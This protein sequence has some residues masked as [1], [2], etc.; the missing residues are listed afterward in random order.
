[1]K[2]EWMGSDNSGGGGD[3]DGDGDVVFLRESK[4]ESYEPIFRD[5]SSSSSSSSAADDQRG[6]GDDHKYLELHELEDKCLFRFLN[7]VVRQMGDSITIHHVFSYPRFRLYVRNRS[8]KRTRGLEHELHTFVDR[9]NYAMM[10]VLAHIRHSC[11]SP[12]LRNVTLMTLLHNQKAS[13]CF[14]NLV[15]ILWRDTL[16]D[17]CSLYTNAFVMN[18]ADAVTQTENWAF[19][20]G[21]KRMPEMD[22]QFQ[23][24][25]RYP[26]PGGEVMSGP[27]TDAD[28]FI[29]P[30]RPFVFFVRMV[31]QCAHLHDVAHLKKV[32]DN[33]QVPDSTLDGLRDARTQDMLGVVFEGVCEMAYGSAQ[34][35]VATQLKMSSLDRVMEWAAR[36]IDNSAMFAQLVGFCI[37]HARMSSRATNPRE[38]VMLRLEQSKTKALELILK[39]YKSE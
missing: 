15:G 38:K 20:V 32:L 10:V 14:A 11:E 7:K 33:L 12:V 19:F 25:E 30:S 31:L 35:L 18:A 37:G 22:A 2:D 23:A 36:R 28:A 1:M 27:S 3:D 8:Q 26:F 21:M 16:L 9:I 29:D 13:M 4:G 17:A 6:G 5:S 24:I 34:L 39:A